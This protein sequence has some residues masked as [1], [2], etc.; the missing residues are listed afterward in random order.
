MGQASSTVFVDRIQRPMACR[1][2]PS[3]GR[4]ATG[5][6]GRRSSAGTTSIWIAVSA[7]CSNYAGVGLGTGHARP[8]GKTGTTR[9][10][11]VAALG[12]GLLL[13]LGI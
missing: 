6:S 1:G 9:F 4:E 10:P 11:F 3:G 12:E 2:G 8:G 5:P 7:G 13:G